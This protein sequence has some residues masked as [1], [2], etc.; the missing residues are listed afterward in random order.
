MLSYRTIG[1]VQ[2]KDIPD[3]KFL[4]AVVTDKIENSYGNGTW[5]P[6]HEW[7]IW[8]SIAKREGWPEKVALAKARSLLKRGLL[9]GC[10]C[11]CRGDLCLTAEGLALIVID[12]TATVSAGAPL[13]LPGP[14][15][16]T[17]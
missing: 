10:G 6:G 13:S 7:A 2:A 1:L 9:T 14:A 11:G 16:S 17:P 4:A 8:W 15:T 12:T 3:R 5:T